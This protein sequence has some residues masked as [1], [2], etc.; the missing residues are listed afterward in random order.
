[1]N[2][3]YWKPRNITPFWCFKEDLRLEGFTEAEAFAHKIWPL[4]DKRIQRSYKNYAKDLK[5]QLRS[6]PE[7]PLPVTN[8]TLLDDFGP[9]QA[10]ILS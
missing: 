10:I 4:L 1:M 5:K 2:R 7:I 3:Y 6:N 8:T 9:N